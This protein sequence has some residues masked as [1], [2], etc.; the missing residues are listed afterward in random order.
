[1]DIYLIACTCYTDPRSIAGYSIRR[2]GKYNQVSGTNL[3]IKNTRKREKNRYINKRFNYAILESSQ[4][5]TPYNLHKLCSATHPWQHHKQ[6][7]CLQ[8]SPSLATEQLEFCAAKDRNCPRSCSRRI[9]ECLHDEL[10]FQSWS[11]LRAASPQHF[12]GKTCVALLTS[13][14]PVPTMAIDFSEPGPAT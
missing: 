12:P 10:L 5:S 3:N 1:M 4:A 9:L 11:P 8:V 6:N 2:Q 7:I 14:R 13:Q